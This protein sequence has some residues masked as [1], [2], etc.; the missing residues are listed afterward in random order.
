M[1]KFGAQ[2][3][4]LAGDGDLGAIGVQNVFLVSVGERTQRECLSEKNDKGSRS[5][6]CGTAIAKPGFLNL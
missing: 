2:K 1:H 4:N 5:K 6:H 3:R